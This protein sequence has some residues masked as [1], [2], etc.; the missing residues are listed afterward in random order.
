MFFTET[1]S[2][3]QKMSGTTLPINGSAKKM[4]DVQYYIVSLGGFPSYFK[5]DKVI[6]FKT[7]TKP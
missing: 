4:I 2:N 7:L 5:L 1:Q 3:S 6:K